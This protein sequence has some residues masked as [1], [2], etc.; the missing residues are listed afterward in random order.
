MEWRKKLKQILMKDI[1]T[2]ELKLKMFWKQPLQILPWVSAVINEIL[3]EKLS[4][5]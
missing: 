1:F 2:Q 5:A 4:V 3:L